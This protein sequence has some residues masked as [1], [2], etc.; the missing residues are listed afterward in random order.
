MP[1]CQSES[2]KRI[3]PPAKGANGTRKSE[4]P[5]PCYHTQLDFNHTP[6]RATKGVGRTQP[7]DWKDAGKA[8]N[9]EELIGCQMPAGPGKDVNPPGA[10]LQYNE[11]SP[12]GFGCLMQND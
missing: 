1:H 6:N 12:D 4:R 3:I 2:P 11:A 9:N 8:L 10:Y 5:P 7:V